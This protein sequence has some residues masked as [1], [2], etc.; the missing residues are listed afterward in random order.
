MLP[1]LIVTARN[2]ARNASRAQRRYRRVLASLPPAPHVPDHAEQLADADDPRRVRL[3]SEVAK[4]RPKDAQLI[5]LT[6]GEGFT[7]R[8]AATAVGTTEAAAKMR[9]SRIR[10]RLSGAITTSILGEGSN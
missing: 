7:V 9:L 1:W 6:M 8:E 10:K 5:A 2:C 4:L 3:R